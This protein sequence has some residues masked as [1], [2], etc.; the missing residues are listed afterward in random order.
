[1]TKNE[2][3]KAIKKSASS[4]RSQ[5][6][7]PKAIR[8]SSTVYVAMQNEFGSGEVERIA[9]NYGFSVEVS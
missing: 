6:G 8:L 2:F 7:E 1:M 9:G 4:I 3:K 5:G